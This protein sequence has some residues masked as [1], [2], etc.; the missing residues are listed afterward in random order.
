MKV[1]PQERLR[2]AWVVASLFAISLYISM[3]INHWVFIATFFFTVWYIIIIV[4]WLHCPYCNQMESL[5][6]L[7]YAINHQYYCRHCGQKIIIEKKRR[8]P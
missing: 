5:I 8:K 1:I 2:I 7:T 6:N 4:K 3:G